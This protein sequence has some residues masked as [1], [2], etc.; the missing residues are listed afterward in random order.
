M[1]NCSDSTFAAEPYRRLPDSRAPTKASCAFPS[2]SRVS[3][4]NLRQDATQA[5]SIHDYQYYRP[6]Q[7][8]VTLPSIYASLAAIGGFHN[9]TLPPIITSNGHQVLGTDVTPLAG[10]S[11]STASSG[12]P[13][14]RYELQRAAPGKPQNEDL[15]R[16]DF[17][18]TP[19]RHVPLNT[20]PADTT[21]EVENELYKEYHCTSG[22]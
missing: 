7:L 14:A 4:Q 12:Y 1:L 3:F 11:D 10:I 15:A 16:L 20:Q 9:V 8:P 22:I 21:E 19:A 2:L 5:D 13:A 18:M 6:S 17:T